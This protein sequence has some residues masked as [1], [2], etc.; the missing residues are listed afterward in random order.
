MIAIIILGP[1]A[2]GL[3]TWMSNGWPANQNRYFMGA[4]TLAI[5]LAFA[6]SKSKV[7]NYTMLTVLITLLTFTIVAAET[8]PFV[9]Q[10]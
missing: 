2:L 6:S 4:L 8:I 10:G 3:A 1:V 9:P 5:V 7:L